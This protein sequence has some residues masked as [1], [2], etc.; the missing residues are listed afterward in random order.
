MMIRYSVEYGKWDPYHYYK[1]CNWLT[2][3]FGRIEDRWDTYVDYYEQCITMDEDVY[4]MYLL[5]WS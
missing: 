4:M 5:K 1:V 2:E 3:N